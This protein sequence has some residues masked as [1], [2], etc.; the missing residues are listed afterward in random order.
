MQPIRIFISS[1]GDVARER[2]ATA[3]VIQRLQDEFAEHAKF[4][5]CD[6]Q[7]DPVD[8]AQDYQSQIPDTSAF[9]I[10]ICLLWSRLGSRLSEHHAFPPGYT[11]ITG[12]GTEYELLQALHGKQHHPQHLPDLLVWVNKAAPPAAT[13]PPLSK[14]DR[15]ERNRQIDALHEFLGTLTRD[16]TTGTF[17]AAVNSYRI[18]DTDLDT[19]QYLDQFEELMEAKL[20]KLIQ[21]HV[22]QITTKP[23]PQ[24]QGSPFRDLDVFEFQHAPIFFGRSRATGEVVR[25]LQETSGNL[26]PCHFA[27][28]LG[29]SG[30][31]KSSLSRAGVLPMLTRPGVIEGVGL[32]RCAI[33]RPS[34]DSSDLFIA[35]AAALLNAGKKI[36]GEK[37]DSSS[38]TAQLSSSNHSFPALPELADPESSDPIRTLADT[39][40]SD[41]NS[42]ALRVEL[43]LSE[44]ARADEV[45]QRRQLEDKIRTFTN[46]GRSIDAEHKRQALDQLTRPPIARLALL[47]DQMEELF[48]LNYAPEQLR[49]FLAAIDV[50]ARSGRVFVL[51]TLR[52]D[53]YPRYQQQPLLVALTTDG[54]RYDLLPPTA[55]EISQIIRRPARLGGLEFEE[56][57]ATRHSLADTLRDEALADPEALP[58]LEHVL[59]RLYET[60]RTRNDARLTFE[61]HRTLGGVGGALGKHAEDTLTQRVPT[62]TDT[63]FDA[64]FRCLITLGEGEQEVPNRRTF[65]YAG[66]V[67]SDPHAQALT[68]T[69]IHERLFV[70]DQDAKRH[71]IV[72]ISHEALL[73]NWPRLTQWLQT[74]QVRDFMSMRRRLESSLRQWHE[75]GRNDDY[76]LPAGLPMEEARQL[77]AKHEAALKQEEREFIQTSK[78]H[79]SKIERRHARL[80]RNVMVALT[81]LTCLALL[82]AGSAWKKANEVGVLL[83]ES[84]AE[85]AER[86][87]AEDD[88]PG[89]I[90]Y[91]SRAV[92]SGF[93][94]PEQI[95]RL[96]FAV[97]Q[98]SWPLPQTPPLQHKTEIM[99]MAFSPD[100]LRFVT[101]T[102]GGIATIFDSISGAQIGADMV[103]PKPV[104][105]ALFSPDGI[106][107]VT[108]CDDAVA[109]LWDVS[110]TNSVPVGSSRHEDQVLSLAWSRSGKYYASGSRD[111]R[112]RVWQVSQP[113]QPVFEAEMKEGV[114]TIAFDPANPDRLLAV[115]KDEFRVWVFSEKKELFNYT[116]TADLSGASFSTDGKMVMSF[117]YQGDVTISD[118][119]TGLMSWGQTPLPAACTDAAFAPDSKTVAAAYGTKVRMM[120]VGESVPTLWERD[121]GDRVLRIKFTTEGKRL[122]VA[123]GNGDVETLELQRGNRVSQPVRETGIPT[124]IDF[125]AQQNQLLIARSGGKAQVWSLQPPT[126]LPIMAFGLGGKPLVL[127]EG[128]DV[129]CMAANGKGTLISGLG[130]GLP[131][132][133]DLDVG[134][135]ITSAILTPGGKEVIA[136]TMDGRLVAC[137]SG[138]GVREIGK[139]PTLIAK[140]AVSPDGGLLVAGGDD[141]FLGAWDWP[142]GNPRKVGWSHKDSISDLAFIS[143]SGMLASV[144]RDQVLLIG[145]IGSGHTSDRT[146]GGEPE[147]IGMSPDHKLGMLV[148]KG[149][150]V[151]QISSDPSSEETGFAAPGSA[152]CIAISA[153]KDLVAVGMTDGQVFVQ[154]LKEK[155]RAAIFSSGDDMVNCLHFSSDGKWLAAGNEDGTAGVWASRTGTKVTEAFHHSKG[156]RK[157][158]LA[159]GGASL[160]SASYDGVVKI[161]LL[162]ASDDIERSQEIA[163]K[164]M[165]LARKTG[166]PRY[167]PRS[168]SG[169]EAKRKALETLLLTPIGKVDEN[170]QDELELFRAYS[171]DK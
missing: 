2:H 59:N 134:G 28:I 99:V 33:M 26:S 70:A 95:Q 138:L 13:A 39:L 148:L 14:V 146:V 136:G 23:K 111:K 43:T 60:Q 34:D 135:G 152:S 85:R 44:A 118:L 104:R 120:A 11:P 137:E 122:I 117:T 167:S 49:A 5:V 76:L 27:L 38:F 159:N 153:G 84:D 171:P 47:L 149:G 52:S 145:L 116:A 121:F 128:E 139:V 35:L 156:V 98:R 102:R 29:A 64:V 109:R 61:D 53:F 7:W 125:S 62:A 103:H 69:F 79:R 123:C 105:G 113:E 147:A 15:D 106:H 30:S 96:L 4:E 131:V 142:S 160:V 50:L 93:A 140:V 119:D 72:R 36:S 74:A 163:R 63:T 110:G 86:L 3:A 115:A 19:Y 48:T 67:E 166:T 54:A 143:P 132:R 82:A 42:V 56:D 162:R 22:G 170:L 24:W 114:H 165:E 164:C 108:G 57:S 158:L 55:D 65:A 75:Q 94:S 41:S 88:A 130:D 92:D 151:S 129:L 157:V 154:D 46:E 141:G 124:G 16:A 107:L 45:R 18:P 144:S 87:F 101:G 73:R 89:G 6:W 77:L 91:L 80:R 90:W 150:E 68:D 161:W 9:D 66:L 126:P 58:L 155:R 71:P 51:G 17:I 100:G 20:R 78:A 83:A 127:E 168:D 97:D 112:I 169:A 25:L 133:K 40:R 81:A 32:W 12:S 21:K 31:G 8:F 10:V 1:P 37:P